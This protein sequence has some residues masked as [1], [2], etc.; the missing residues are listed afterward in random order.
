MTRKERT[1][2]RIE[3]VRMPKRPVNETPTDLLRPDSGDV[4][5]LI[6]AD[7]GIEVGLFALSMLPDG[8]ASACIIVLN[9]PGARDYFVVAFDAFALLIMVPAT[10]GDVTAKGMQS[11]RIE[12]GEY[13]Q[14]GGL[15]AM[16][17]ELGLLAV[18]MII[19]I[20]WA[21]RRAKK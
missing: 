13:L 10:L 1:C 16:L 19:G 21:M 8:L 12:F 17:F 5:G 7:P 14:F 3:H 20:F 4:F 18:P 11:F 2:C 9:R 6:H 15:P